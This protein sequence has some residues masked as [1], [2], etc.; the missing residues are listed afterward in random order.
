MSTNKAT[1]SP[2][3]PNTVVVA[4]TYP[5]NYVNAYANISIPT[6]V[7]AVNY[8]TWNVLNQSDMVE[9]G[10]ATLRFDVLLELFSSK[11][12]DVFEVQEA[13]EKAIENGNIS[14]STLFQHLPFLVDAKIF[15]ADTARKHI[16][17]AA[18][19]E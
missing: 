19:D 9:I 4:G 6:T 3:C 13:I 2:A 1:P 10:T 18:L 12:V 14:S 15:T 5:S 8:G 16:G 17:L 11:I 7:P